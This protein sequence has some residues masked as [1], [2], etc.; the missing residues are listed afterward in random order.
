MSLQAMTEQEVQENMEDITNTIRY[1]KETRRREFDKGN[2]IAKYSNKI[3]GLIRD[4]Y[5]YEIY[6]IR[7]FSGGSQNA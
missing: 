2:D 7:T 3:L 1:L 5:Q 4:L 6:K